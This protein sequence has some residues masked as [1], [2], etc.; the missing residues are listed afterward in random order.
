MDN[1]ITKLSA[2][3]FVFQDHILGDAVCSI[4]LSLT[5]EFNR[6]SS[7]QNIV[8]N[9]ELSQ[10][11]ALDQTLLNINKSTSC[12][13]CE[14]ILKYTDTICLSSKS[15]NIYY[16]VNKS[17]PDK[18]N[19]NSK[20]T[21]GFIRRGKIEFYVK[22]TDIL[23]PTTSYI[24]YTKIHVVKIIKTLN[25]NSDLLY[26]DHT[27]IKKVIKNSNIIQSRSQTDT[28][29]ATSAAGDLAVESASKI[30]LIVSTTNDIIT[31]A[32]EAS[33][34]SQIN[35][36]RIATSKL[37]VPTKQIIQLANTVVKSFRSS[38]NKESEILN[39]ITP[40]VQCHSLNNTTHIYVDAVIASVPTT[41]TKNINIV[42]IGEN[43]NILTSK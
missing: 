31:E 27:E 33:V 30:P 28:L 41:Y 11:F 8:H 24:K 23:D 21:N 17:D 13:N 25:I 43:L 3:V 15:N 16:F 12:E 14:I 38:N 34:K 10:Y 7:S 22:Q 20:N 4:I 36:F 37:D 1:N 29:Y 26:P 40:N 2:L 39:I 18:K 6:I 19:T 35:N 5:E 32:K 42:S 9:L